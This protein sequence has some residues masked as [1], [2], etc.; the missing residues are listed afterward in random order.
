MG[1]NEGIKL[2]LTAYENAQTRQQRE[3]ENTRADERF[4]MDKDR[5]TRE[6]A[7][8]DEER[9]RQRVAWSDQD[10]LNVGI[11][12][13]REKSLKDLNNPWT[14]SN[15]QAQAGLR[16]SAAQGFEGY[17]APAYAATQGLEPSYIRRQREALAGRVSVAGRDRGA[18]AG[19]MDEDRKLEMGNTAAQINSYVLGATPEQLA[20]LGSKVTLDKRNQYE[21]KVD[22][23]TGMSTVVHGDKKVELSRNDLGKFM[24]ASY[25]LKQGDASA[26]AEIDGIDTKLTGIVNASLT[27]AAAR[28]KVDNDVR[29][30]VDNT[31]IASDTQATTAARN[32]VLGS[33]ATRT[34]EEIARHNRELERTARANAAKAPRGAP[35]QLVNE[36]GE[37]GLFYLDRTNAKTGMIELPT[38]WRFPNQKSGTEVIKGEDGTNVVVNSRTKTPLFHID[39]QGRQ[40]PPGADTWAG[41]GVAA[42]W[43][44]KGVDRQPGQDSETG[45][46]SF[47]YFDIQNPG[48]PGLDSPEA[49]LQ[50]RAAED[51]LRKAVPGLRPQSGDNVSPVIY[52]NSN[53]P[54]PTGA[55]EQAPVAASG[56]MGMTHQGSYSQTGTEIDARRALVVDAQRGL[57]AAKTDLRIKIARKTP[58]SREEQRLAQEFGLISYGS[59][60]K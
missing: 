20:E 32:L 45:V 16:P 49:V 10:K 36:K 48:R 34:A 28:A 6:T 44:A 57:A 51:K 47:Q 54:Q 8:Q 21:I 15:W 52:S 19:A 40:L 11:D 37:A 38:G 56:P 43:G 41:K 3:R 22:E 2:G 55:V 14:E 50:R 25:R 23:K 30:K 13:Y 46:V 35:Q 1:W 29:Y 12:A 17:E 42:G 4:A 9:G 39:A 18:I 53:P 26:A 27:V 60:Y 24:A 31:K 7:W 33:D 58:L 5:I 59:A